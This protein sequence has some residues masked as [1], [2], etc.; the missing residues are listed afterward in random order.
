MADGGVEDTKVALAL[1]IA[2]VMKLFQKSGEA[3]AASNQQVTRPGQ[4]EHCSRSVGLVYPRY[5]DPACGPTMLPSRRGSVHSH[6]C[7]VMRLVLK[8]K[9]MPQPQSALSSS[10]PKAHLS[11][12]VAKHRREH[13]WHIHCMTREQQM[14][15]I[16][17]ARAARLHEQQ[18]ESGSSA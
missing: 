18:A 8:S 12:G 14:A 3:A 15:L 1:R 2:L 9:A 11:K 13:L 17:E 6:R 5:S 4:H 10:A 7:M 16:E